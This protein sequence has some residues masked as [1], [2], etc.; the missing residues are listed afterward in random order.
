MVTKEEKQKVRRLTYIAYFVGELVIWNLFFFL[1]MESLEEAMKNHNINLDFSYS[2][3][4]S[5]GN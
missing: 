5:H 2:N 4:S 3:S 1:N